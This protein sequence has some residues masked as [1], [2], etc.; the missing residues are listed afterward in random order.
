MNQT[1]A[2]RDTRHCSRYARGNDIFRSVL[3]AALAVGN[4][5]PPVFVSDLDD[6]SPTD[7]LL[8]HR[9]NYALGRR[10]RGV[11]MKFSRGCVWDCAFSSD[12]TFIAF[13]RAQRAFAVDER[14][15]V[16]K[17]ASAITTARLTNLAVLKTICATTVR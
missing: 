13:V 1:E 12:L 8:C 5:T 7:D 17:F 2:I 11:S 16:R 4:K 6:L 14:D 15:D 3:G 9:L 10:A